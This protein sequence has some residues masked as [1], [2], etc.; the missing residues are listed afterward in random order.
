MKWLDLFG[1]LGSFFR[2]GLA[3]VRLKN[4]SGNLEVRNADDSAD[5]SI[6]ASNVLVSGESITLND[7]AA[8]SGADWTYTID[9]PTSG[10]TGNQTLTLPAG[11]GTAGQALVTDGAGNLS[12]A[13]AGNTAS[14]LKVDTT[15]IAFDASSPVSMFSTG[16]GDVIDYVEVIV[17]TP[18]DGTPSL[19][20]GISGTAS[21]Y[22]AST[23]VD[24]TAA[25]RTGFRVHPQYTAQGV[26]AL[27]AT[28]SAG[29]ATAGSCRVHV[30]YATP[31]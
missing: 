14:S 29:G 24:L 26:E 25:A 4:V 28:L 20:I 3:G 10:M 21:K 15:T 13:S 22:M 5:A 27:I 12:Y 31:A 19:S 6:T 18:F 1:T 17:D 8:G 23:Q 30:A 16:S 2:I 11:L 7:D 9:R